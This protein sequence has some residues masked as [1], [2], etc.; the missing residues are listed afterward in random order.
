MR[1]AS[2]KLLSSVTPET[3]VAFDT[4]TTGVDSKS[5]KIVGFS[6]C[7]NDED[8]YYVPVAHNYLGAPKQ[9]DL[10]FATW[11]VGKFIKA[12]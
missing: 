6:F 5:A 9:I 11:A 3:I 2:K 7:F 8:A 10:K 4:E 1:Q 12:A